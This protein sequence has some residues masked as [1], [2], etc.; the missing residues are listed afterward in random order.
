VNSPEIPKIVNTLNIV[1]ADTRKLVKNIDQKV[2]S[3]GST[4]DETLK[5][6]GKLA[7]NVDDQVQ[8]LASTIEETVRDTHKLVRN[9]DARIEP[10]T[11]DFEE[12]AQ[13]ATK[14][15]V[16]ARDTLSTLGEDSEMVYEL[17]KMLREL[18]AAARSMRILADYFERHPDA[19]VQGKGDAGGK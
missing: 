9:V 8:P 3:I 12:T 16:Q 1:L 17:T 19:L 11:A 7:R 10:L 18:A 5:D 13:E 2:A 6:Y 4:A 15:L 14:A